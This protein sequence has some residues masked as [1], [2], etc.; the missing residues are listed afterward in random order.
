M[1]IPGSIGIVV[2]LM[3]FSIST[4]KCQQPE[5][6]YSYTEMFS[7]LLS[8]S[9]LFRHGG[10]SSSLLFVPSMS[11]IG[12]WFHKKQG[13]ATGVA[14]TGGSAGGIV[15]PTI[16]LYLGPKL[17]FPWT[18]RVIGFICCG[19][20]AISCVLLRTRL[21]PN[22]RAGATVDL[23]ALKD[24]KYGTTTL[25][26]FFIEFAI[27]IPLTYIS[28]Y[29]IHVGI[30]TQSAYRLVVFLNAASVLGRAIPGYFADRYGRFN[31]MALTSS[32]CAIFILVLW[33]L[34]GRDERSITAFAIMFGFWSGTAI[35]L[36]PVCIA[37]VS[38]REDYGKRN[39]TT[40]AISSFGALLGIPI[41][42]AILGRSATNYY[43]L[44]LF[45]GILY[46]L[47][48]ATFLVTRMLAGGWRARF[49][50]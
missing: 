28:L 24:V 6:V 20:C 32:V 50:Y 29:A 40:F 49:I 3:C 12:H 14:F 31:I 9:T 25:A 7:S 35:A 46:L 4:C 22:K 15:F 37:Q 17:G 18:I 48:S 41:A 27:F 1:V 43:S 30:K 45:G 38:S 2:A 39:G 19:L 11:T 16:V 44:I 8:I 21:P 36:S 42:G 33:L 5:I 34:C 47:G 23:R 26:V 10:L 13:L